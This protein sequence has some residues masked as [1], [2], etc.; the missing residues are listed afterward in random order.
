MNKYDLILAAATA[1]RDGDLLKAERLLGLALKEDQ[2]DV[3]ALWRM[4]LVRWQ[5]WR[6][7]DEAYSLLLEAIRSAP[8]FDPPRRVLYAIC[9]EAMD[10]KDEHDWLLSR[11]A[12][13]G[14]APRWVVDLGAFSGTWTRRAVRHFPDARHLMV[15]ANPAMKETLVAEAGSLTAP[16]DIAMTMI[17][18]EKAAARDFFQNGLG[19]SAFEENS[20]VF[21]YASRISVPVT[22]LEDLFAERS[23]A[24]PTFLK[25]DVQGAELEVL[26]GAGRA[27]DQVSLVLCEVNVVPSYKGCPQIDEIIAFLR[28]HGF[29]A[30]DIIEPKRGKNG[31][32][33]QIDLAYM[34]ESSGLAF[35]GLV[36]FG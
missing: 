1:Q 11:L 32:L 16:V 19:S 30:Y 35:T 23:V 4:G 8:D 33:L 26:E 13:A 6:N 29:S 2:T 7:F 10:Q 31:R 12:A 14:Y 34:Q 36:E 28:G 27:L 21:E 15:E 25:M 18:R 9:R 24:G 20:G 3:N 22:T 5:L 17:G